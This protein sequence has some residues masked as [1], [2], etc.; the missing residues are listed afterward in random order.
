MVKGILYQ[1]LLKAILY[2]LA[3]LVLY[4]VFAGTGLALIL[5]LFVGL[6]FSSLAAEGLR[7]TVSGEQRESLV[8][9]LTGTY[10]KL[11]PEGRAIE[12]A[13]LKLDPRLPAGE[14]ARAQVNNAMSGYRPPR[15]KRELIAEA[16]GVVAFAILIPLDIALYT[17]DFFSLRTPQ[18]WEGAVVAALCLVLYSWPHRWLKS[19]AF[20]KPRILWWALPFAVTLLL[21]NR[22]IET[23]IPI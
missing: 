23:R 9:E 11:T 10:E 1:Y 17:R 16:L 4:G 15:P 2:A 14:L 20:S 12:A 7:K 6:R 5:M 8:G 18:G 22:A 3:A 13:A 21:L 19:I